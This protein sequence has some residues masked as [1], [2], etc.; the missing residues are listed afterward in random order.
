M[1]RIIFTLHTHIFTFDRK[2]KRYIKCKS[3]EEFHSPLPRTNIPFF[4]FNSCT[5]PSL[6]TLHCQVQNHLYSP[7]TYFHLCQ[8]IFRTSQGKNSGDKNSNP[9]LTITKF[10]LLFSL[11][12][13]TLTLHPPTPCKKISVLSQKIWRTSQ[14]KSKTR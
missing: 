13:F 2:R 12:R 8:E 14:G 6:F 7:H 9:P 10:P 1:Y 3:R 5:L 11:I 4:S